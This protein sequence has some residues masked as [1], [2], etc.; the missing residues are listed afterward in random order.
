[1]QQQRL[2]AYL[3]LI[4]ELLTCPHGEEWIWLRKHES[5]VNPE[6]VQVMEQVAAQ[7]AR[8]GD[9]QS[10]RFIHNWAGQLHHILS[11]PTE[12]ESPREDKSQAYLELIQTLLDS[13][14]MTAQILQAHQSL[15]GPELV[16]T[17]GQVAAELATGGNGEAAQFLETVAEQVNLAWMES[18]GFTPRWQKPGV[19]VPPS[20]PPD[21]QPPRESPAMSTAAAIPDQPLPVP[22]Q[23][24]PQGTAADRSFLAMDG[25]VQPLAAIATAI[26][27]LTAQIQNLPQGHHALWYMEALEKAAANGWVL[28]TEEVEQLIGIKPHCTAGEQSFQRGSWNFIKVGR[29]GPQT[30]W[31]V[32]KATPAE[33]PTAT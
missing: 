26:S 2:K 7:L 8:Q 6:L 32:V 20:K 30:G 33:L 1:M 29:L 15:L 3:D 17:M 16:Q 31:Q 9:A 21:P 11:R 5:L 28:S 22:D 4:Q 12:P 23:P 14:E 25:L 18:H 13:P 27:N 19:A 10:A 24:V